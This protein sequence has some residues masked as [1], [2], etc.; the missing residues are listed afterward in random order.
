MPMFTPVGD[1]R[2]DTYPLL[3]RTLFM[4]DA[5]RAHHLAQTALRWSAPWSLVGRTQRAIDPSL[6]TDL[7]GI[8]LA[9]PIGLAPGFDKSALVVRSLA[10]L[11]FG[12]VVIG[13]VT[14]LPRSGN[15]RPRMF[16]D[17]PN[18]ALLNS[19]GLPNTGI[20]AVIET[21][22]KL[23][24]VGAP[25][26][27]SVA[28]FSSAELV[29]LAERIQPHV[30]AVEIGL[31]CPNSTPE[32]QLDELGIFEE[33]CRGLARIRNRP[34]FVKLPT[35]HTPEQDEHVARM[36]Q[37]CVDAGIEGVSVSGTK[38]KKDARLSSGEGTIAGRP[39]LDE[40]IRCVGLV[41]DRTGGK[42]QIKGSGG[43]FTGHDAARMLAAGAT[44]VEIYTSF[45][46]RGWGVA[47]KI[48]DE[49]VR[50]RSIALAPVPAQG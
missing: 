3:R 42:L 18:E 34:M 27:G 45:I 9:S 1:R 26:I 44:T 35:F 8:P 39:I 11:G 33:L 21:L 2:V 25:I 40:S 22:S 13:S 31:I 49:L 46:Y 15:P 50:E 29:E 47:H 36:A 23:D 12:Y 20:D 32:E 37:M 5:E 38:R 16:R 28:G 41:A 19:L 43:V 4:L 7:A 6:H 24:D 14:K 17:I 10:N 30:A 48:A